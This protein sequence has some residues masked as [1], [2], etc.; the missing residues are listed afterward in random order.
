[1]AAREQNIPSSYPRQA[2]NSELS[3][4]SK[5]TSMPST[6]QDQDDRCQLMQH[7]SHG[8]QD[9]LDPADSDEEW[10]KKCTKIYNKRVTEHTRILPLY[11]V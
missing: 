8:A 3:L 6:N 9:H 11:L 2:T 7:N 5:L 10:H 4:S 1:M